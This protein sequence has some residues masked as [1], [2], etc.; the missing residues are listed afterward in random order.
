MQQKIRA[1]F[2][3]LAI[4]TIFSIPV[5]AEPTA[6][7]ALDYRKAVM[8][9]LR[10][11][12][13]A[14]SMITRGLVEDGGHLVGHAEGLASGAKELH[15]VFQEG[16]NV[17]ESEALPAIWQQPE[18]FAAAIAKTEEATAAFVAAAKSGD[19]EAIGAAFRNVGMSCRGCHDN[20]R[21]AHE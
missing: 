1:V 17:G 3:A 9:A 10:G 18:E 20:Y 6:E 12:I 19:R 14:S 8:T 13:G 21:V 7:D 15:R 16:S 11:H 4:S 5:L 2:A